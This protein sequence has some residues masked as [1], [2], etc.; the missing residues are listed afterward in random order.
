MHGGSSN[1]GPYQA[2][3]GVLERGGFDPGD[4]GLDGDATPNLCGRGQE[5]S[6]II[7]N[8]LFH[9]VQSSESLHLFSKFNPSSLH[10]VSDLCRKAC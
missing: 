3:V 5:D 7:T 6:M 9:Q 4:L 2:M 1:W 8:G 10:P